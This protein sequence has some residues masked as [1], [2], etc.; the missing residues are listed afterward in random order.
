MSRI[1]IIG[2]GAVGLLIASYLAERHEITL[3]TRRVNDG[4]KRIVRDD[5]PSAVVKVQSIACFESQDLVFVTTKSYDIKSVIPYLEHEISPVVFLQNGMGHLDVARSLP[6]AVFGVVEHGAMKVGPYEVKHTGKGRIR[7]G[8][9][10][11]PMLERDELRFEHVPNIEDVMLTKLFMN[12]VI[13]PLTA[14]HRVEN[15][16]LLDEPFASKARSVFAELQSVFPSHEIKYEEVEQILK[17]T[18]LNRSSMLRDIEQGRLTEIEPIVGY[19]LQQAT[20]PTP[21]LR[22]YFEQIKRLEQGED[23]L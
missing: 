8:N 17:T 7:Y 4:F 1:G 16:R 9:Q 13:N 23:L 20:R 15:G 5:K 12:A 14:Y 2:A 11:L 21:V 19:V 6:S 10:E 3:Y 22:Y 18:R